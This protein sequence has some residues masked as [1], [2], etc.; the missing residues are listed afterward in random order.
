MVGG[1]EPAGRPLR[2]RQRTV[3]SR[4]NC[5]PPTSMPSCPGSSGSAVASRSCRRRRPESDVLLPP[6]SAAGRRLMAEEA[7]G[8][9][10]RRL[11]AHPPDAPVRDQAPGSLG[12]GAVPQVRRQE[13]GPDRG[14]QA[15]VHVRAAR[16][17]AGGPDRR[18]LRGRPG[19]RA[20]GGLLLSPA[21]ALTCRGAIPLCGRSRARV[22]ARTW[23]EADALRSALTKLATALGADGE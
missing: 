23:P 14:P 15:R 22:A 9:L 3:R 5:R 6:R 12:R 7:Y 21:E 20:D 2:E 8:R 4:S 13:A 19:V 1:T 16:L 11:Q 17:R 10:G 18:E